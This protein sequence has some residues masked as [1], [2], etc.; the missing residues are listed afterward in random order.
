MSSEGNAFGASAYQH[1]FRRSRSPCYR[2]RGD[3][4]HWPSR[5]RAKQLRTKSGPRQ[6]LTSGRYSKQL[7]CFATAR[8]SVPNCTQ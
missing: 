6:R 2:G 7:Q 4:P 8:R 3:G 1:K 5:N